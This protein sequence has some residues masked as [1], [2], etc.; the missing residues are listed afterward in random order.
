[1]LKCANGTNLM[2]LK[3]A[4]VQL[5]IENRIFT[6]EVLIASELNVPFIIGRN[7]FTMNSLTIEFSKDSHE[8]QVLSVNQNECMENVFD[9]FNHLF[10]DEIS[11]ADSPITHTIDTINEEPVNCRPYRVSKFE[12]DI[13]AKEIQ[14]ILESNI[15]QPSCSSWASPVVLIK[16]KDDSYR[17]CEI[18]KN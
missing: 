3:K 9:E 11:V 13:I 4:K 7:F 1:M 5:L 6:E 12:D 17:F 15:I 8:I 14:K 16:K 18:T 2:V 10:T